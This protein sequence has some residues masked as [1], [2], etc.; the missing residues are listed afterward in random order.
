[1]TE[2]E[3]NYPEK[4]SIFIKKHMLRISEPNYVQC[5]RHVYQCF[6]Q[7]CTTREKNWPVTGTEK[8]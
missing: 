7:T 8:Q 3:L 5:V 2:S 6:D 1:M 4:W